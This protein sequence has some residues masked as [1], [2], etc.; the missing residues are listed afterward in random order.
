M[1]K[2]EELTKGACSEMKKNLPN[3]LCGIP[4]QAKTEYT[5]RY[6]V[7][8]TSLAAII[9]PDPKGNVPK[10]EE[11]NIYDGPDVWNPALEVP[12]GETDVLTIISNRRLGI[13]NPWMGYRFEENQTSSNSSPQNGKVQGNF[14][15]LRKRELATITPGSGWKYQGSLPGTCDGSFQ[16]ECGRLKSSSCLLSGQ[17][18]SKGGIQGTESNGWLVMK[19]ENV[20]YGIIIVKL[21]QEGSNENDFEFEYAIDGVVKSSQHEAFRADKKVPEDERN[22]YVLLDDKSMLNSGKSKD[23]EVAIQLKKTGKSS[24]MLTHVYWG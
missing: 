23:M 16:S 7:E 3:R 12:D 19:L 8:K 24:V 14:N 15:N 18:D 1:K 21:V 22:L 4:M 6:D 11:K 20:K 2:T 5:P 10:M 9:K 13:M 17:V